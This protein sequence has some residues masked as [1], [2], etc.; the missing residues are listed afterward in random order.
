[1]DDI[2]VA[3]IAFTALRVLVRQYDLAGGAVDTLRAM[4]DAQKAGKVRYLGASIDGDLAHR[5]I[6][7]GDFDVMQMGY[8]LIHQGNAEN[9]RL[10]HERGI[11]VFIRSGL[12]N[13]LL[14]SRVVSNMDRL[15]ER[16]REKVQ[17]LLALVEGDTDKLT[18]LG[19]QFLY[20]NEGISSVIVGTK[21]PENVVKNVALLDAVLPAGMLEE[22]KRIIAG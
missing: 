13:G 15:G 17:Q 3:N 7:S 4:Q 12:G 19:L 11:G 6:M 10:A 14:T 16:D 9:I 2:A 8:N 18:A 20:E 5:C 21:K 1:M 22:A